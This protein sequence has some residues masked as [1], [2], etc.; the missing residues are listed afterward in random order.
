[1][2][3]GQPDDIDVPPRAQKMSP[4]PRN[5]QGPAMRPPNLSP[6]FASLI[7]E[8]RIRATNQGW[9]CYSQSGANVLVF[10][11]VAARSVRLHCNELKAKLRLYN[12]FMREEVIRREPPMCYCLRFFFHSMRHLGYLG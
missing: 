9:P 7:L 11:R 10:G 6:D 8:Q 5:T 3:A 2:A 4:A 1:V 12:M